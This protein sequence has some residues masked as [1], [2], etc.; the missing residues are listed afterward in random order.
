VRR[1]RSRGSRFPLA[2]ALSGIITTLLFSPT[3]PARSA[4]ADL[5]P[6]TEGPAPGFTLDALSGGRVDLA[7]YRGRV[8]LVHFFATWCEPCREE[9][10]ALQRLTDRMAGKPV[11]V[12]AVN[13]AEVDGRVRRFF[14]SERIK[15]AVVLDRDRAVTRAWQVF[16]LPTTV[17]LDRELIPRLIAEGDIDWD[18]PAVDETLGR[19]MEGK[20]VGTRSNDCPQCSD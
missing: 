18:R 3:G 20:N 10:A 14:E 8:V 6:W 15:F 19:L 16:A 4:Q 13:V 7:D 12:L 17:V 2:V 1:C 5:K 11:T 9:I